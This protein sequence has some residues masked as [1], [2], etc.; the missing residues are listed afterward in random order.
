[1][2]WFKLI[3]TDSLCIENNLRFMIHLILK[4]TV[5]IRSLFYNSED[6]KRCNIFAIHCCLNTLS[7][8]KVLGFVLI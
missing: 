1:M 8:V 2:R 7:D 5:E 4:V 6:A 3:D